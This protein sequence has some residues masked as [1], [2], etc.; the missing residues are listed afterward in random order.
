MFSLIFFYSL[1]QTLN[2]IYEFFEFKTK[3]LSFKLAKKNTA[4]S[5]LRAN[6]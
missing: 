4:V 2:F 5:S 3:N 6:V 1:L